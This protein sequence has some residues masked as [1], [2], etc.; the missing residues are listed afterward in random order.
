MGDTH[1]H[2]HIPDN[3]RVEVDVPRLEAL[4]QEMR[5][6]FE[7]L[8]ATLNGIGI[9][10]SEASD[11]LTAAVQSVQTGFDALNTTLQTEM[12]EIAAALSSAGT[13]QALRDA[14]ADA[15]ARLQTLGTSIADMNTTVQGIIP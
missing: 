3:L 2:V 8:I 13:D 9:T 10:M 5:F 15:V 12:T 1:I 6:G 11:Q 4:R 7:Q 14:A